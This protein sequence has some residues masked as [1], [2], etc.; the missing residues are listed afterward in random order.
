MTGS[1]IFALVLN[2]EHA[3]IDD[4]LPRPPPP[5]GPAP[6][7]TVSIGQVEGAMNCCNRNRSPGDQLRSKLSARASG[8]RAPDGYGETARS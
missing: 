1:A 5:G 8:G 3:G 7:R 6:A 4:Q 2:S